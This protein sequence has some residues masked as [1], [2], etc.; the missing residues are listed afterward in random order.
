M[1]L[2]DKIKRA[3]KKKKWTQARLAKSTGLSKNYIA[4][5]EEGRERPRIKTLAI[6]AES[7]DIDIDKL[8]RK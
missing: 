2:G 7:L 5:I 3:R 4:A 6:I 8:M 1:R